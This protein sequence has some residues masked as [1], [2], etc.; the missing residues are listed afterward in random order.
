MEAV[1]DAVDELLAQVE[2][3]GQGRGHVVRDEAVD[4]A[5][6]VL[7][8]PVH[9]ARDGSDVLFAQLELL[10][11]GDVDA[12]GVGRARVVG[13]E[14]GYDLKLARRCRR[15][16]LVEEVG[17][18]VLIEHLADGGGHLLEEAAR[19]PRARIAAADVEQVHD[20]AEGV[21]RVVEQEARVANGVDHVVRGLLAKADVEA[22]ADQVDVELDGA[23]DELHGG[24]AVGAELGRQ[25]V[26]LDAQYALGVRM[27]ELDL[28]E[29]ALVVEDHAVDADAIRV[30]EVRDL[31]VGVGEQDALGRDVVHDERL[32][33]A[34]ARAVEAHAQIGHELEHHAVVVA[35]QRVQRLHAR[36]AL[37]PLQ[38]TQ[39]DLVQVGHK[40]RIFFYVLFY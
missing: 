18:K 14:L 13:A 3:V 21:A 33:L 30:D 34:L 16:R 32:D 36:Q 40:E 28:H 12:E 7:L 19:L 25:A 35:L 1:V 17:G 20:V 15:A 11:G 5:A 24:F 10:F 6:D 9:V 29:L 37:H 31:L 22:D 27:I 39:V 2:R 23:L 4:R 26:A 8:G 38:V